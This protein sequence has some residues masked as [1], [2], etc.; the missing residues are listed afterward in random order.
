ME[1]ERI[2]M[3]SKLADLNYA[4]TLVIKSTHESRVRG[5][6]GFHATFHVTIWPMDLVF[7]SMSIG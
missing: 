5:P 2:T 1:S 6:Y 7:M 4:H 3:V